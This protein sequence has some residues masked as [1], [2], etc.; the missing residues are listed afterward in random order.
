MEQSTY[1]L[2]E[3]FL[4]KIWK[5]KYRGQRQK[6]FLMKFLGEEKEINIKT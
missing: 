5:G 6:W 3:K 1:E 4:G 2:P